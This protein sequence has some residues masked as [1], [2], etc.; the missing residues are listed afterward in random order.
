MTANDDKA[1]RASEWR[2]VGSPRASPASVSVITG[3]E[4]AEKATPL[5]RPPS[6]FLVF[7]FFSPI[8]FHSSLLI[9]AATAHTPHPPRHPLLF[10]FYC[11]SL[12]FSCRR[13]YIYIFSTN[14]SFVRSLLGLP[15][16][17]GS[18]PRFA[19]W[20]SLLLGDVSSPLLVLCAGDVAV[21]ERC[22]LALEIRRFCTALWYTNAGSK[23]HIV[24]GCTTAF[25]SVW[26]R[27]YLLSLCVA[28][29]AV[30][31]ASLAYPL[32]AVPPAPLGRPLRFR[33]ATQYLVVLSTLVYSRS[34]R[35]FLVVGRRLG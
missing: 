2:W 27:V 20:L 16:L 35:I 8:F 7:I 10:F 31:F 19:V 12:L 22:W 24:L 3:T 26:E 25:V 13:Y 11:S 4:R 30:F 32:D 29:Y 15:L 1:K 6:V 33:R 21:R 23:V 17:C 18:A 28:D 9:A 14:N 5:R 34:S